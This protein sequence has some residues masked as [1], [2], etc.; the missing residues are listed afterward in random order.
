MLL[1]KFLD[2]VTFNFYCKNY[3]ACLATNIR[4]TTKQFPFLD[5]KDSTSISHAFLDMVILIY[6]DLV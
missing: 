4:V 2:M 1:Q 5:M 6:G 3:L